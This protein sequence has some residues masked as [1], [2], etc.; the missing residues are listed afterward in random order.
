VNSGCKWLYHKSFGGYRRQK[1][2]F[3]SGKKSK[4]R[5]RFFDFLPLFKI[6]F[7]A[8][9]GDLSYE[10]ATTKEERANL[11]NRKAIFEICSLH[12][13]FSL[14]ILS[15]TGGREG[16]GYSHKAL[17]MSGLIP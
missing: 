3:Q 4:N 8:A 10:T 7:A 16:G 15:R 9:G 6:L 14:P 5:K 13:S 2:F 12:K 1:K 11:K 17:I